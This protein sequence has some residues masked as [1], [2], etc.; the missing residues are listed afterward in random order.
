MTVTKRE[1]K[2][3]EHIEIELLIEAVYRKYGYDFRNY[4]RA[5][6]RRRIMHRLA[7]DE[8]PSITEMQHRVLTDIRFLETLL[9][10][11]SINTTEMFRDP[12]YYSVLRTEV[13]PIL[14]TYPSFKIWH[15][16]CS[17][18]EE[19]YSTAIVLKEEGLYERA[20][21]YATD[22][23]EAVLKKAKE[24]VFPIDLMRQFTTN[25]QKSGGKEEFSKYFISNQ[26]AVMMDKSLRKNVMFADHNL[27]TDGV[28][29]EMNLI[30]CR[31][32]LIYFNRQ[33]QDRVIRLFRD[34][35]VHR[36]ILCLGSKETLQ[37]SDCAQDF[38][39]LVEKERIYEKRN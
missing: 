20:I 4:A 7:L 9:L 3:N 16:G 1:P 30:M 5:S 10:D 38:R 12:T 39:S 22:F 13:V 35:L 2:N 26:R 14:R 11:L 37:F 32:V 27:V 18:G 19:V 33:L 15:A 8:I 24:G 17:T 6:L 21:I 29:G 36:G 23:N 34:S 28:F 31:N 25:Y